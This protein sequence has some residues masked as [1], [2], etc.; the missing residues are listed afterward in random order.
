MNCVV[1]GVSVCSTTA[2]FKVYCMC[3][4][5]VVEICVCTM[6]GPFCQRAQCVCVYCAWT[7]INRYGVC[8][9]VCVWLYV[10][11]CN[12]YMPWVC[13]VLVCPITTCDMHPFSLERG[14]GQEMAAALS[15]QESG[16]TQHHQKHRIFKQ[17]Y[18]EGE[19]LNY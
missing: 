18:T 10:C 5:G 3:M 14:S 19:Q 13:L 1:V 15:P 7:L 17:K 6:P 8:K 2:T 4:L 9:C 16:P 11:V 12:H